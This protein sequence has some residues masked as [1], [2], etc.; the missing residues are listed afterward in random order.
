MTTEQLTL[1]DALAQGELAQKR[2]LYAA[3]PA[4]VREVEAVVLSL[5]SGQ[6][7]IAEDVVSYVAT[8]TSGIKTPNNKAIGPII[9]RLAREGYIRKTG[10]ARPART[11]HGSLKPEWERV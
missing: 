7:F 8:N 11:S 2:V 10:R 5:W 3:D 9:K 4:W 1:E 6:T